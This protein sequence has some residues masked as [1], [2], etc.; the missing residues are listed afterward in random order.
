MRSDLATAILIEWIADGG[1]ASSDS[2]RVTK[3]QWSILRA[4][5]NL[6]ANRCEALHIA[7]YLS[8]PQASVSRELRK[9]QLQGL[10]TASRSVSDQRVKLFTLTSQGASAPKRDPIF[11]L[12]SAIAQLPEA[13]KEKFEQTVRK[14]ALQLVAELE[15]DG[16]A[17][18][19]GVM[20]A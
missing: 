13:D 18:A 20:R 5:Q 7:R 3:L 19:I 12:A 11:L 9:M 1:S 15:L 8:T 4:M 6:S 16:D 2:S 17:T 14:L 10:V